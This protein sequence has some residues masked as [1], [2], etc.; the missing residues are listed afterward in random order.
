MNQYK[1]VIDIDLYALGEKMGLS[2]CEIDRAI[3]EESFCE[4]P[5]NNLKLID[6]SVELYKGSYYGTISSKDFK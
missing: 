2:H 4:P 3:K 6:S 5:N 1:K